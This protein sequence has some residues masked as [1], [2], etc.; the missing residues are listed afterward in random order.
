MGEK[1]KYAENVSMTP[2]E[3]KKLIDKYG[4]PDTKL[5]IDKLDNS[6][7]SKGYVYKSDY[8]AILN[9]VVG[10]V[11]GKREKEKKTNKPPQQGN[12]DQ[13]PIP[14][15]LDKFTKNPCKEG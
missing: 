8:R 15:D 11:I 1:T 13:R 10:E 12:F 9:W 6:K 4:E 7:G 5:L 2:D 14:D 3:Y